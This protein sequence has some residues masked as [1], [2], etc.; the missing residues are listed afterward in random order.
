MY[1][2]QKRRSVENLMYTARKRRSD[3]AERS[4][5]DGLRRHDF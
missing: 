3:D 4:W 2:M 1:T 5:K